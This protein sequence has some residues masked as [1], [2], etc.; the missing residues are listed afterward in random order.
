MGTRLSRTVPR[1]T[2]FASVNAGPPG[3]EVVVYIPVWVLMAAAGREGR[4]AD[5]VGELGG[6]AVVVAAANEEAVVSGRYPALAGRGSVPHLLDQRRAGAGLG[7]PSVTLV[8]EGW[9]PIGLGAI[10]DV[11]QDALGPVDLERS[12]VELAACVEPAAGCPACGAR[13]FGFP[14]ELGG[15]APAM[16]PAHRAEANSVSTERFERAHML[17]PQRLGGCAGHL[18]APGAAPPA[19]RPGG[20][21]GRRRAAHVRAA[22][23]GRGGRGEVPGPRRGGPLVSGRA[24]DLAVALGAEVDMPWLPEW[25]ENLVL[26]LGRAGL[27][28]EAVGAADALIRI[29]PDNESTYAA[30]LGCA[31]AEAGDP[32][33]ARARIEAN[34]ARWPDEP[35]VRV[36]AGDALQELGDADGAEA[37]FLAALAIADEADDFE[38]RSDV[39]DRLAELR[40]A[41]TPRT[42]TRLAGAGGGR[43][44]SRNARLGRNDPC[45]CGSGRKYKRCHGQQA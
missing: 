20:Q 21:D 36:H 14:G 42:T 25:M 32:A 9:E 24:E 12:P 33:A 3:L 11:V 29:D 1:R 40:R 4:V 37:H 28:A 35:W 45:F 6:S 23:A 41:P 43:R 15:A 5:V 34:V 2:A 18:P 10:S 22:G 27:A 16:C 30:D 17:N 39:F 38:L 8:S 13:R 7:M 26:D 19:Q 31:L 44:A